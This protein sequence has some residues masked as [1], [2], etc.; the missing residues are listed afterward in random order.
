[1]QLG[2]LPAMG[3]SIAEPQK[4]GQEAQADLILSYAVR[5]GASWSTT[6]TWPGDWM[7]K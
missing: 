3:G 6:T 4:L 1:M 7:K 2:L 5:A